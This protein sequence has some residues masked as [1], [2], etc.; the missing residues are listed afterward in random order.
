MYKPKA[1][2]IFLNRVCPRTCP[3]CNVVDTKLER[4]RLHTEDWKKVFR[5]LENLGTEFYLILGTEPLMMGDEIVELVKFWNDRKYEYGFYTT[6]PEPYFSRLSD[7]LRKVGIRNWSSGIDFIPEVYETGKWS[8]VTRMLVE[9]GS[10]ELVRK[11]REGIKG[12]KKMEDV[13][14][15]THSLITISRMNIEMVPD[16]VKYLVDNIKHIHIGLNFV[17]YSKEDVMDFA[18]NS[19]VPYFFTERDT[20]LLRTLRAKLK[21]LPRKYRKHIQTPMSYFDNIQ[22]IINLDWHCNLEDM[23]LGVECDGTLRLCGYKKLRKKYSVFDLETKADEI[24]MEIEKE[25]ERCGGC[26]WAYPFI[27]KELGVDG[28]NYQSEYWK[29]RLRE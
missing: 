29:R 9:R 27:L 19:D 17:E 2:S 16:I 12:M 28:V 24:F 6:S 14:E 7:K 11:G 20:Y 23:A 22:H 8:D 3:Y 4:R 1:V 5:I 18:K 25:W 26:Y 21:N 15:E 13:V 10:K